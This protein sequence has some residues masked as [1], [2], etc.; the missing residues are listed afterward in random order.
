MRGKMEKKKLF[1]IGNS[2]IDPVWFWNWDEGLQEVKATFTS[3]LDR[4][5]EFPE[6]KFTSTSTV[7]FEWIERTV[8]EMFEEIKKRVEEG[9]WEITGGWFLE[10]DC[11]LP[12]GEAFVR[13]G[14]YGQRYL[15][16]RFNKTAKIGSNVD[17][18]GHSESLP[19][20][21]KKSGMDEYIFMRPRLNTPVFKWESADGSQIN[22]I[23]LPSEYTTWFFEPTKEAMEIAIAAMEEKTELSNM[24]CCYGVGNHGGGPTIQNIM[25]VKTLQDEFTDYDIDFGTYRECFD[26]I[27]KENKELPM[28]S[29]SMEHINEGC[30]TMDARL[31]RMNRLTEKR[32]LGTDFL[33]SM[34]AGLKGDWAKETEEMERLWKGLLFNQ[35]HDT[36][37]GTCVKDA[38]DEG[39]F[40]VS[41]VCADCKNIKALLYQGIVNQ[42]DTRGEG[43]PL[44]LFNLSGEAYSGPVTVELNWFCKDSL[45]LLD[46]QGE[47][48]PYQ[49]LHTK[50]KVRNYNLGGRRAITFF[51][52]IP[53]AGFA[54]YRTLTSHSDLVSCD[55]WTLEEK[56]PYLLENDLT[57]AVFDKKTGCLTSLIDKTTGYESL[58]APAYLEVWD[59]QRD[60]WGGKMEG[61]LYQKREDAFTLA[62]IEKVESGKIRQCIRVIYTCQENRLEQRYYLYTG[63]KEIVI[64]NQLLWN[65]P[66]QQLRWEL[67]LSMEHAV[68]QA[69]CAYGIKKRMEE[70]ED[71]EFYMHRFVDAADEDGKGL[72]IAN[73]SRYSFGTKD[74]VFRMVLARSSIY[75]QGNGKNWYEP[76]ETYDYTDIGKM[77]FTLCIQPHGTP[78]DTKTWFDLAAI[79]EVPYEYMTDNC[80]TGS[81]KATTYSLLHTDCKEV[82][83]G[84]VKKAEDD[85]CFIVRL[86]ETAGE[87]HSASLILLG[88][89]Y[90]YEIAPHELKTLKIDVKAGKQQEV[91]L[92]EW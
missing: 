82:H 38:R 60:T 33:L 79:A 54:M 56:D 71:R 52:K 62:S 87:S 36:L 68:T 74:G 14:L 21:L 37:G 39:I 4:M 41:K 29:A 59:D 76:L 55:D 32:L 7:F 20:I 61:F 81:Q 11:I 19:Q 51:A 8:P 80:H 78:C 26:A 63:R 24:P 92:V 83:I 64:E 3:A 9:R 47:E 10:P 75:A 25:A 73:N 2:H 6:V 69:E 46:A 17:S 15:K 86:Q 91:N 23:S 89:K 48:I 12:C 70:S 44:F 57:K 43:F 45:R 31:K 28:L 84:A 77:D 85:E 30:Y 18:F 42:I 13:Q 40:Q 34:H 53:A 50:A 1:M 58:R 5:R 16:S 67:P 27:Y 66:W 49:R 72:V 65:R 88:Q 22:C 35:F 90:S